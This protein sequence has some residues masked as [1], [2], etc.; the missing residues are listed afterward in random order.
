MKVSTIIESS[1][2]ETLTAD[3]LLNKL[4]SIEIDHRTRAKIKNLGAPTMTLVSRD[5]PS[6]ANPS[7]ASFALSSLLF[8]LE[9]Q[10]ECLWDEALA[11]VVS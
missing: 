3:E 9:E 7:P 11:L 4:K 6:L 8:L 10:V 2:Y 5:G 1:N